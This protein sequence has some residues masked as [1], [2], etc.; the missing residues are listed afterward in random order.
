MQRVA[1]TE[2]GEGVIRVDGIH[3][4]LPHAA[5]VM[6][7]LPHGFIAVQRGRHRWERREKLG[8]K[9]FGWQLGLP[10]VPQLCQMVYEVPADAVVRNEHNEGR[11]V[12]HVGVCHT[13][14][15]VV[16]EHHRQR[17]KGKT[18]IK[19]TTNV[20]VTRGLGSHLWH[21]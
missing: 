4:E 2:C 10:S 3:E 19:R 11:V 8:S 6:D 16:V 1:L 18:V 13:P 9:L 21:K 17:T 20:P 5:E 7:V 15:V 14:D 12:Q